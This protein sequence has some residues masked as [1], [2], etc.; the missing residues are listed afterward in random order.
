MAFRIKTG[1]GA[2]P[3]DPESLLRD[4]RK[5]K[6]PG[7]L[8]HQAD[9]IRSYLEIPNTTQ[10][11]ALQLP[12]G[13]GKTLVGLLIAEW[14]R[15]KYG[16]RTVYL[17]P[18]RQLV[19]QIANHASEKY[20]LDVLAFIGKKA[21]YDS[22]AMADWQSADAVGITTYSS[23]FNVNP[24][25]SDPNLI[26][27]DDAHS[28]ENYI[29][30]FWSLQV[31]RLAETQKSTFAALV[32]VLAPLLPSSE[33]SNLTADTTKADSRWVD[34][35]PTP[36]VESVHDELLSLLDEYTADTD[37]WFRWQKIR[38]SLGACHVYVSAWSI[39][40]RPLVPPTNTHAPFAG[41]KQRIYMSATLGAGGDLER[42]TGRSPIKRVPVP[43]GW[44]KQGIGRRFFVFP[45]RSLEK[46]DVDNCV[47]EAIKSY[48]RALYLVPDDRS[49]N[50]CKEWVQKAVGF[51]VFDATQI[52][53][54]KHPFV[55]SDEAVAV[56]ANRYDGIDLVDE[57]CRMLLVKG[58]PRGANLQERFVVVRMGANLLL[59]D[60]ILTRV[61]QGFGRCTRSPNDYAAV[62]VLGEN[63]QKYL[64]TSERRK[65]FHPEIQAE[66]EFGLEQSRNTSSA[67]IVE[68]LAHFLEQDN[69]WHEADNGIV[70]LR[71]GLA[72]EKLP[73]TDELAAAVKHEISYQY[74]M[75]HGDYSDALTH[76]RSVLAELT[77]E[78]LRGY[79]ALWLY[80]SGS[81]AWLAFKNGHLDSNEIA[82]DYFRNASQAAQG[83]RWL[84]RLQKMQAVDGDVD[85]V[86]DDGVEALV[87]RLEIVIEELKTT[88]DRRYNE[89]EAEIRKAINQ[90]EDGKLF[91]RGHERLGYLIGYKSGNSEEEG[92]PDPWWQIDDSYCF[93]FEDYS[94]AGRESVLS[95]TKARQAASHPNWV[96]DKLKLK[97]HTMITPVLVT[98]SRKTSEGAIPHLRNVSYWHLPDFQKWA[99]NALAVI[100]ELRSK[101]P[102]ECNIGWRAE[103][104]N[105]LRKAN[106]GPKQLLAFLPKS[107]A[108][109]MSV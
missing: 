67:E 92:A 27:L 4:L 44:D 102:G 55:E 57:E 36:D 42:I 8:S 77:H 106:I 97:N 54:S 59:D 33:R 14:R 84:I 6:I 51:P 64:M 98:S 49:S 108:D 75:W 66:L 109:E 89:L 17:C 23:L 56:V 50:D 87:E 101:Y 7:L 99:C 80:L 95:V 94:E 74:S 3:A 40:I 79:R 9:M 26:I 25:F 46:D 2:C 30:S 22:Q 82:C 39:L 71:E 83:L 69:R 18:T 90:T 5:K 37:M 68:N 28:A 15:R 1:K 53:E 93:V 19:N 60:R 85:V 103:A 29:S 48:G 31:D 47:A 63:L 107:A 32:S 81:A 34:K 21:N 35:I 88:H 91:E 24:F 73:A 43:S 16:E 38:G 11:V 12:T 61:V 10:D 70:E 41:A 20:G 62:L 65:F 13:S 52:E 72:Q 104:A 76:C 96:R 100:R 45:Q 58:L 105:A 78:Q 86:V